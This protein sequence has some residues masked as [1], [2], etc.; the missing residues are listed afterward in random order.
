MKWVVNAEYGGTGGRP[1]EAGMIIEEPDI[2]IGAG[3]SSKAI[4]Q[5]IHLRPKGES[6]GG[7][8]GR[9]QQQQ[10]QQPQQ[11]Q[12]WN[13]AGGFP[14]QQQQGMPVGFPPF[15]MMPGQPGM[16]GGAGGGQFP[17]FMMP[18][19]MQAFFQQQFGQ[20]QHVGEEGFSGGVSEQHEN[21]GQQ[22][23]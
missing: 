1:L 17:P 11:Q 2:E 20:G 6:S 10:Q 22:Q 18:P 12:N 5:K 8:G 3:V 14:Q 16:F 23:Q 9:Q 7:R 4:S 21:E 13:N 15:P 19:Q